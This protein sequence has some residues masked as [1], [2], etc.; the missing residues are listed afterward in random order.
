MGSISTT[1][2]LSTFVII[3]L[4]AV[5][6]I[7]FNVG[8]GEVGIV[9][10]FG[11][12]QAFDSGFNTKW[13]FFSDVTKLSTK[14]QIL[15]QKHIVPTNEGLSV[16]LDTAL[17]FR[18]NHEKAA[19]LYST[20]GNRYINTLIGPVTSSSILGLTSKF[21]AKA[22]YTSSRSTIQEQLKANITSKLGPWG[23]IVEDVLLKDITLPK[24]L[25]ASIELK[26]QAE[27]DSKRMEFILDKER[28]EAKRKAIEAKGVAD[29]QRIV[30]EG[31]SPQLLQW[32]GIEVTEQIADNGNPKVVV[33]GN[34]PGDLPV[35]FSTD[36]AGS[37]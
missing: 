15:E 33:I 3:A 4:S 5:V 8:P 6:Q 37:D 34:S 9:V 27:Q 36:G 32:K 23:I 20:V 14:T 11:H 31:I 26:A 22:L 30:S 25:S 1:V 10:T 16:N 18:I 35:L 17:L 24:L 19:E 2:C 13:P 29:F 28:Q 7:G 21:D 12:I